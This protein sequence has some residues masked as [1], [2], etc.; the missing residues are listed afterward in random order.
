MTDLDTAYNYRGFTSHR[1]LAATA[2]DLLGQFTISTKVGF[3]PSSR[4]PEHCLDPARLR[5]AVH[6]SVQDMG[7]KP[8]VVLLHNPEQTLGE[9]APEQD[10]DSWAAACTALDDMATAGW[11]RSWGVAC[12]DPRPVLTVL[13]RGLPTPALVMV[14]VGLLVRAEI[15]D[16]SDKLA[17][18]WGLDAH[19]RWGMSPYGGQATHPV[20]NEVDARQFLQESQDC[21]P[22]PAAFRVAY[23]LPRVGR[24]AVSTSSSKHLAELVAATVLDTDGNRIARYRALLRAKVL[25]TEAS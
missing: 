17:T 9:L 24:V 11:C 25:T 10:H 7:A 14:R 12:W 4:G 22:I 16:A 8:E 13:D 6:Q 21:S 15:L 1:G 5:Q 2:G 20:W 19:A 18:W 3:F 23:E